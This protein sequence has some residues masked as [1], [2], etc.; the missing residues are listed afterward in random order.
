MSSRIWHNPRIW[1]RRCHRWGAAAIAAPFLLVLATGILLQVKK[2]L[3]W[4]QPPEKRGSA[5]E[6]T[7]AFSEILA[8][9]RGVPE[10]EVR[11]WEDIDRLDVR[12]DKGMIKVQAKS[13]WEIQVDA[14]TGAVLHSAYRRSDLIESL[15]DGSWFHAGAKVW[16]F[17]PVAL[18]VLGLWMTGLYLL[19]LPYRARRAARRR[20]FAMAHPA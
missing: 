6:P 19:V 8:V 1:N 11:G 13:R 7:L 2:Q 4:V 15:H 9:T 5:S 12:P 17:L 18:V 3:H 20:R 16:I 14:V 10:A